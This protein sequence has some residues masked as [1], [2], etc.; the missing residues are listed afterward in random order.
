MVV[1]VQPSVERTAMCILT[2]HHVY[3]DYYLIPPTSL[4]CS[5][6]TQNLRSSTV[7]QITKQC[8]RPRPKVN[9]QATHQTL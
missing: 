7:E 2:I 5:D 6:N 8:P 1:T 9:M 4:L 3:F